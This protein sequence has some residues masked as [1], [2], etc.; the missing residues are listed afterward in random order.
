MLRKTVYPCLLFFG[1][2]LVGGG[3]Y[4]VIGSGVDA[5]WEYLVYLFPEKLKTYNAVTD[6]AGYAVY[7]AISR[8]VA[9]FLLLLLLSY[10]SLRCDNGRFEHTARLK[11]GKFTLPE[12][13]SHYFKKYII[14]DLVI[15]TVPTLLLTFPAALLPKRFMNAGFDLPFWCGGALMPYM[16]VAVA[17]AV[18]LSL[19]VIARLLAVLIAVK[20]YRAAWLS[21]GI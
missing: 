18:A 17:L 6:A 1:L 14:S 16:G 12:G 2:F 13:Y 4:P 11:D 19:T 20:R 7:A 8:S 10:L 15:C 9:V 5:V 21:G 3:I